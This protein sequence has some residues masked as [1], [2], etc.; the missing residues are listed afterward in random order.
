VT[1]ELTFD[2]TKVFANRLEQ[3]HEGGGGGFLR[4]GIQVVRSD[5]IDAGVST[6]AAA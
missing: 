5:H 6:S 4:G 1:S 2:F 3:L